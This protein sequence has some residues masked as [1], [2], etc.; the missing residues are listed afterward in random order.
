MMKINYKNLTLSELESLL[1]E[2]GEP[3]FRAKQLYDWIFVKGRCDWSEM[4]NLPQSLCIRLAERGYISQLTTLTCQRSKDGTEKYLFRLEDDLIETVKIPHEYGLSVCVSTQVGCRMGCSFCASTINGLRRN[5]SSGEIY[6]QVLQLEKTAVRDGKHIT[7]IVMMGMGEPLDNYEQ[8]LRFIR[9][10]TAKE[11]LNISARRITLSTC[12]L[13]PEIN[14]LMKEE[15]PITLAV[16]LHAPDNKLRDSLMPINKKYPLE[17][18]LPACRKYAEITGRRL[19]FEYAL[20]KGVND[21]GQEANQLAALMH[22]W[23]CH[24]NLI[25]IN[26]VK[27]RDYLRSEDKNIAAFCSVLE[28]KHISYTIRKE[29]GA[30]IDAACGQLRRR[31]EMDF[32]S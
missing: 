26:R 16:S 4:T 25:P 24:V 2:M 1:Y 9:Q 32:S 30:D 5:L 18:L 29:M 15:L 22:G 19:T 12:G 23:L 14:Q 10:I 21:S 8:C 11:S 20:I 28:K 6:D 13:V 31:Y 7:H 3:R 17:V 27:E